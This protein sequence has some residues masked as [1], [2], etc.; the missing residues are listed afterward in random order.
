M[1]GFTLRLFVIPAIALALVASAFITSPALAQEQALK[2]GSTA[3]SLN[4]EFLQ[5]E[6]NGLSDESKTYIVE[7]WATWCPPCMKSIPHLNELAQKFR[8][9]GLVILGISDE[10]ITTVKPFLTKKGSAMGYPVAIDKDKKTNQDW[11]KAAK[12]DGIP[13]AFIVRSNKILW[14]GNPLDPQ[15]DAV[16][17]ASVSG[18]YNPELAKQAAPLIKAARDAVRLKNFNDAWR[19]LDAVIALDKKA[20]GDVAVRKY[21][22]MLVEANDPTGAATWGAQVLTMYS[23]DPTTLAELATVIASDDRVTTRD[24]PLALKAADAAAGAT[25]GPAMLALRAEVLYRSGNATEAAELQFQAWMAADPLDKA[26]FKRALDNYKKAST[27]KAS[28]T[29]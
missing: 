20:F 15:F 14:I 23:D 27:A 6:F 18:R 28:L 3:P 24:F 17:T 11:M 26:D 13:C 16:V 7:F 4:V 22:T 25:P 12:Q 1:L 2:V 8:S 21:V 5:G 10:P 9:R 19:H 29:K